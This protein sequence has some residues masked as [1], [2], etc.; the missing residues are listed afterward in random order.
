MKIFSI[1]AYYTMSNCFYWVTGQAWANWVNHF[2]FN[3]ELPVYKKSILHQETEDEQVKSLVDR[4]SAFIAGELWMTF[5]FKLMGS[6]ETAATNNN[7][8]K[9]TENIQ[10]K[11]EKGGLSFVLFKSWRAYGV[12]A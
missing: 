7:A 9:K 8:A 3:T 10:V 6:K 11:V 2:V 1:I 5:D 4:K 12:L